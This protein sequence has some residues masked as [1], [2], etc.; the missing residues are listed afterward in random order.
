MMRA[1]A[2]NTMVMSSVFTPNIRE[3][4]NDACPLFG[5][6]DTALQRIDRDGRLALTPHHCAALSWST[7][8]AGVLHENHWLAV[9]VQ[10][11]M[12]RS[13]SSFSPSELSIALTG[14]ITA[15]AI[16]LS[17]PDALLGQVLEE[18]SLELAGAATQDLSNLARMLRFQ[19]TGSQRFL[20]E[21]IEDIAR[22]GAGGWRTLHLRR[23]VPLIRSNKESEAQHI[24]L[25]RNCCLEEIALRPRRSTD[26]DAGNWLE[27]AK[28]RKH[29][30]QLLLALLDYGG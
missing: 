13:L 15:K 9:R 27:A 12:S 11:E 4:W 21:V 10:E 26:P 3:G 2:E 24:E 16:K 23:V 8:R 14:L 1:S 28:E 18:R 7:A 25:F 22:Q 17:P 29:T 6:V 19:G 20:A 5:W 30:K